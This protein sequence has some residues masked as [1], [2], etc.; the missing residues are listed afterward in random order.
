[1]VKSKVKVRNIFKNVEIITRIDGGGNTLLFSELLSV[2]KV[3]HKTGDLD[4]PVTGIAYDSRKVQPG[5]VF[6]AIKGYVTDGHKYISDALQRGAVALI[7][8]EELLQDDIPMVKVEDSR[9]ALA[10]A[11][12]K[13]YNHP[14]QRITITGVTGTNGKTTTTHLVANIYKAAGNKTG[15]VGT[16]QNLV[17]GKEVPATNTTPESL[18]LQQLLDGMEK[19]GVTHAAMEV[20]SHALA[21]NRT[22]AVDFDAAVFTNLSQDHLDFHSN[23]DDYAAAKAKLFATA[24]LAIV[25]VDDDRGEEMVKAS[26]GT[27]VTYGLNK[28]AD[29]SAK[30]VLVTAR[31]VSFITTGKFGEHNLNLKLTGKFNVYNALAA[32]TL[33]MAQGFDAETVI[34]ALEG[35]NGVAGRFELVD[36]GQPFGVV[37]DYAHTPDGLKNILETAR[38]VTENRLISVFGCGGDRDRTKRPIMGELGTT[39]SDHAV[40]T[41]DNPRT[42]NPNSIIK[43]ILEGVKKS[44]D[45]QQKHTVIE[46]RRDAINHAIKDAQPGDVVV[47]AGKGHETYQVIGTT[48]YDF[49]DREVAANALKERGYFQES[50]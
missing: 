27:V 48:K 3:C 24:P 10:K 26:N 7:A 25:N 9:M 45:W 30:D 28:N 40:I 50:E 15:L 2:I 11:A 35:V 44:A 29:V 5:F 42:E 16:I 23:M 49:D 18:D 6:V 1:M 37:V 32:F 20:S 12:D 31:G 36:L 41:S 39:L 34:T 43:D 4:V 47:I 19:S 38:Q 21:L 46:G 8:E 13:F 22:Y 17:G 14:S 33:G